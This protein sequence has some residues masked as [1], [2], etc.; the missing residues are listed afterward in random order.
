MIFTAYCSLSLYLFVKTGK[1]VPP[2]LECK[3]V[4]LNINFGHNRELMEKC[5]TLREYSRF[6]AMIR[7]QMSGE[8][9]FEEAVERAVDTCIRQGILSEILRKNR[10]EVIDMILTEYNEEE[11]SL[12]EGEAEQYVKKVLD[13]LDE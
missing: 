2:A 11:F 10:S 8:L 3:A 13:N 7:Q 5:V 6:V 1:E 12:S 4:V 9:P